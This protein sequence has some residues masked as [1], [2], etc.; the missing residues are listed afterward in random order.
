MTRGMYRD[1]RYFEQLAAKAGIAHLGWVQQIIQSPL[2]LQ[3]PRYRRKLEKY[4]FFRIQQTVKNDHPFLPAPPRDEITQG[5]YQ[6]CDVVDGMGPSYPA[7][8]PARRMLQ[9][10]LISGPIGCGKT[11]VLAMLAADMHQSATHSANEERC[12]ATWVF[13]TEGGQIPS[14]LAK[15]PDI[16]IIHVKTMFKLNRWKAPSG[17]CPKQHIA[18]L[19]VQDRENRHAR[20]NMM[21]MIRDAA[22][23]LLNRQR[24]FN[25]RQLLDHICAKKFKVGGREFHA[26]ESNVVRQRDSLEYM[27]SIYDTMRSHD[28]RALSK[29]SIVWDLHDLAPDHYAMLIGDLILF[30]LETMPVLRSPTLLLTLFLDE[31]R[32]ICNLQRLKRADIQEPYLVEAFRKYRKRGISLVVGIQELH[33]IPRPILSNIDGFWMAFRPADGYSARIIS[34]N[35]MLERDQIEYAM[36]LPSRHVLCKTADYPRAFLGSVGEI[37]PPLASEEEIAERTEYTQKVLDSLLE[38]E[39]ESDQ[40]ELFSETPTPEQAET[41][42]GYYDL[43]K[44]CLDYLQFLAQRVTTLLPITDLDEADNLSQYMAHQIRQQLE[45]TGP[46]LIRIHRISTGRRGGPL[47]VVQITEAGYHLL[48]KLGVPCQPPAGHGGVDHSFWQHAIYRW[49]LARGYPA[50]IEKWHNGKSVDVA[51]EWD[52]KKVAVEVALEDMEKE[53]NNLVKDMEAGWDQIVFA[54]L[55]SKELNELK[56]QIAKRFGTNVLETKK[57]TF[58]KLSTFLDA[59]KVA[60]DKTD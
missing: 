20:D 36:E 5:D 16:L 58:M 17:V 44:R 56:N 21:L 60:E 18:K 2:R 40:L 24:V 25:E 4:A 53:M 23:E 41:L 54:A 42:F 50:Q 48:N 12:P 37:T 43:D 45:D 10:G 7:T 51:I 32:D 29:R 27:G 15:Y 11:T 35:M 30:L 55:S 9:N 3:D 52:E 14:L 6:L 47:S 38:P 33:S 59:K 34:D 39:P 22:F 57:V 1:R 19:S 46:G 8:L 26:Q 13:D 31:L 49:A 28:I